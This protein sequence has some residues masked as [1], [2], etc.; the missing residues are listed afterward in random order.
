M[1]ASNKGSNVNGKKQSKKGKVNKKI[2]VNDNENTIID[3]SAHECCIC[4]EFISKIDVVL[5]CRTC[6]SYMHSFCFD[7]DAS[8]QMYEYLSN[9]SNSRRVHIYC[10]QCAGLPSPDILS[11]VNKVID[12]RILKLEERLEFTLRTITERAN[13]RTYAS[14]VTGSSETTSN[15]TSSFIQPQTHRSVQHEVSEAMDV[16]K[17]KRNIIVFNLPATSSKDTDRVAALFEHL[18][19]T[20]SPTFRCCRIGKPKAEKA[21]PLLFQFA[22][23]FDRVDILQSAHKLKD[24]QAEWPRVGIAPDRTKQQQERYHQ[25]RNLRKTTRQPTTQQTARTVTEQ[26]NA[27]SRKVEQHVSS[28]STVS[29]SPITLHDANQT[30]VKTVN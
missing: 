12:E 25:Q 6:H 10:P 21:Q 16:E 3:V 2:I 20:V 11:R 7:P 23:E 27:G 24:M 29:L 18:T 22:S 9:E 8:T 15:N 13:E 14:A 17:R 28:F 30:S 26:H 1:A 5:K 4:E 19:G